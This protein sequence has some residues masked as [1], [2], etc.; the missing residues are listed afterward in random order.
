MFQTWQ[1]ERGTCR[2]RFPDTAN[3][4]GPGYCPKCGGPLQPISRSYGNH[5]SG[6]REITPD[7]PIIEALLDNIRSAYNVGS[8][9]RTADGAGIRRLHLCGI[10]PTPNHPKVAKTALGAESN[11][12]WTYY[13]NAMDAVVNMQDDGYQVWAI[14]SDST[15]ESIFDAAL[16]DWTKPIVLVVGNELAGVEPELMSGSDRVVSL[17]MQGGKRSLNVTV[18]FGIAAY[19]LRFNHHRSRDGTIIS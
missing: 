15:S 17:P 9:F 1:C 2:F 14:E 18:A 6:K 16:D 7:G 5:F 3:T 19:F 11:V 12:P 8:M 10:T 13:N 4:G